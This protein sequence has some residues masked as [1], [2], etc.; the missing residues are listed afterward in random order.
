MAIE[1]ELLG[2]HALGVRNI[3]ALTGDPPRVGDYPT[4]TG[5]WDVD[6]IGLIG[7]HQAAQPWRGP[8]R[9]ADRRAGRLHGRLRARPDRRR[10]RPRDR[11]A[12]GQDRRRRRPDHDPAHLRARA[13]GPLHG[14]RIAA[15]AGGIPPTGA[16]RRAAAAH[17]RHAEFLHNEVPGITIPDEV[18]AAMQ[19]AGE[20]G[21]EVGLEMAQRCSTRWHGASR[22]RT[23]CPASAATSR[24]RPWRRV[25]A[26]AA[27]A[28]RLAP[29]AYERPAPGPRAAGL[30]GPA[31]PG[32]DPGPPPPGPPPTPPPGG[33]SRT[34]SPPTPLPSRQASVSRR[35]PK[36]SSGPGAEL[37]VYTQYK[38]GSTEES[39][40]RDAIALIDQWGVGRAGFDDGM[41]MMWNTIARHAC[42]RQRQRPGPALRRAVA[43]ARHTRRAERQDIFDEHHGAAPARV[44]Q[45]RR[46]ARG[47]GAAQA[48]G[49]ARARTTSLN[50]ARQINAIVGSRRTAPLVCWSSGPWS[51]W[52]HYGQ[53][54]VY[55]DDPSIL[56]PAAARPDGGLGSRSCGRAERRASADHGHARSRQP[57]L[58]HL[59]R[60]ESGHA[61][62]QERV[63]DQRAR[64]ER[65]LRA[66]QP[67]PAAEP[68]PRNTRYGA[69]RTSPAPRATT[70]A[71]RDAQVRQD[72]RRPSTRRIERHVVGEGWFNEKPKKVTAALGRARHPGHCRRDR[73]IIVGF[74]L[75]CRRP[76]GVG[77]ALLAAA[78]RHLDHRPRDAPRTMAGAMIYAMLA[79]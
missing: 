78:V 23:S 40:E 21:A 52:L 34:M 53:D 33:S 71:R 27:P 26:R 29:P 32:S 17:R 75:P 67:P 20:R 69:G 66:A 18:R 57:R 77:G 45:G 65:S 41:A 16:A 25:P 64:D 14:A 10:H 9:Q 46:P 48:P 31:P 6:S 8:G 13:V 5:I 11:A 62:D 76:V 22:A 30:P 12:G 35:S 50:A 37:V 28:R 63:P 42:E 51:P 54:P 74:N 7:D 3:I 39:T 2:A 60:G 68:R 70:R 36:S 4:A 1:S 47:D 59:R 44:R 79:A 24:P 43:T 15:L 19:A 49:H 58:H 72:R 61:L 55:L 56:M 73:L 38:P